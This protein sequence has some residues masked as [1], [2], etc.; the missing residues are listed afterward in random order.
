MFLDFE[1]KKSAEEV[2]T[3]VAAVLQPRSGKIKLATLYHDPVVQGKLRDVLWS[4]RDEPIVCFNAAAE[5]RGL[6]AL[7]LNPLD[8]KWFDLMLVARMLYNKPGSTRVKGLVD[9]CE[10]SGVLYQH[11]DI[12]QDM[13]HMI[14]SQH[15]YTKKDMDNILY[16]C[17]DDTRVLEPLQAVLMNQLCTR[18]NVQKEGVRSKI[19]YLSKFPACMGICEQTGI[20]LDMELVNN[21]LKNYKKCKFAVIET[22]IYPFWRFDHGTNEYVQSNAIFT[23][24]IINAGFAKN[25]PRTDSNQFAADAV[26]LKN[27]ADRSPELRSLYETLHIVGQL[28]FFNPKKTKPTDRKFI[29]SVGSDGR[30]RPYFNAYGTQTGRNAPPATS[31]IFAMSSVFRA[32]IRP[33]KGYAITGVDW[34]SQEFAIAAHLSQDDSMLSAYYSGDPY[35]YFAK[36]AG[37]VPT[38]GEIKDYKVERQL[39]KSTTLGL[40]YG[41]GVTSL[42]LKLSTDTGRTVTEREALMLIRLHKKIYSQYWAWIK[43]LDTAIGKH[44]PLFTSDGWGIQTTRQYIISLRNF[45]VQGTGASIL[46]LA[47]LLAL[48]KNLTVIAPLHDAIYIEHREGDVESIELLKKCMNAAVETLLPG[49]TIHLDT[50]THTHNDVWVEEKAEKTY[51]IIKHFFQKDPKVKTKQWLR[52]EILAGNLFESLREARK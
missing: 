11:A 21:I 40:Q 13:V 16:Y 44:R 49:L 10:R 51:K 22:C 9:V 23:D 18:Y 48:K 37:A 14:L 52:P 47:C 3:L 5:S 36:M 28:K 31:F 27:N 41:M 29:D 42:A 6:Q 33:K 34:S 32:A 30:L 1:Y 25:W 20:P 2:L 26:T 45:L 17:A 39:F 7:G 35:F 8:F 46:R 19:M 4:L 24:Y 15:T 38:D 50:E 43:T 12:K